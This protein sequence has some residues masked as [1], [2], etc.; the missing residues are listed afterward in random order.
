MR[1]LAALLLLCFCVQSLSATT[2]RELT[3]VKG[4]G[5]FIMRGLGL[6]IG[7]RGTGDDGKEL[8]VA[9]PLAELLRNSGNTVA[10]PRELTKAKAAALVM[11]TCIIPPR[12]AKA[13]D[14]YD[15]RV[16]VLYSASSLAGGQL[17]LTAMRGPWVDSPVFALAEGLIEIPDPATPTVGVVRGAARLI[18][19]IPGPVMTDE[20]DLIIE[21]P[22]AGWSA[23]TQIAVAIN[24]KADPLNN[25]VATAIDERT[26]RVVVPAVERS[27]RAAFLADV[28]SAEVNPAML[29]LPAQVIVNMRSGAIII[30][31]DVQI[32]PVAITQRD[33]SITTVTPPPAGTPLNPV[34]T[35]SA[36][37]DLKTSA[38]EADTAK[39][40]D[41][42]SGFKQ[43]AIPVQE[44]VNILQMLH[45]SGHLQARLVIDQ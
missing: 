32:R 20:F 40:S 45:K 19:D 33:L 28:F 18:E 44:Q 1:T 4:E 23:A 30:T 17:F 13:D 38:S 7:L 22:Y 42:I 35:R 43:L 16:S 34:V 14:R 29:D 41:L 10:S 31:G 11:V 21:S 2:V 5:E 9:R 6:V 24:G 36:W 15:V 3:R 26:I 27:N 12:G 37:T 39:L 8:A 25:S